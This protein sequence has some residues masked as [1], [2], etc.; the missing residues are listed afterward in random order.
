MKNKISTLV[1]GLIATS[2]LAQELTPVLNQDVFEGSQLRLTSLNYYASNRFNNDLMDKFIFGGEITADIKDH[3]SNKLK[4]NNTIGAESEQRLTYYNGN[5]NPLGKENYG[6]MAS[7]S[8]NHL[9]SSTIA[10]DLF[11]TAMYGN[12]NYIGD[13]M[14]FSLTH[15]QYQHFQ[16]VGIGVFD[17][18]TLS[19]I[20]LSYVAG[21]KGVQ[22]RLTN[23]EMVSQQDTITLLLQ[24]NG[25]QS[26]Q[27]SPYWAFQ[28]SG[29]ALDM[30]YNFLFNS[31]K[32][33]PQAISLMVSNI[34]F[35][36]W[37]KNTHIYSIDSTTTYTGFDVKN[38]INQPEGTTNTFNFVDTLGLRDRQ[39]KKITSLPIEFSLQ[40]VPLKNSS[41]K[42]QSILGF[43]TIL[44][45]DYFPYIFAGLYYAPNA[46]FSAS[47][48]LSYGGFGGFQWGLSLNY[49]LKDRAFISVS[50][51][52]MIGNISKK[53]G[54]GRSANLAIHFNF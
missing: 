46:N 49:W 32:G 39:D 6:I 27:F 42:L 41:Q 53:L 45:S 35:I 23:S 40:K 14:D 22:G 18:R 9:I 1:L 17:K 19:G 20:Q 2:A 48:R 51:F 28:G 3:A 10:T 24:G 34:G 7:I 16:K 31:K 26:D 50:S 4:S 44:T 12:A 52:D 8:D 21:S 37:N 25:Y 43:K 11:R 54:Y 38:F 33:N 30:N 13:T 29:V 36:A 5:I 15:F 47:T